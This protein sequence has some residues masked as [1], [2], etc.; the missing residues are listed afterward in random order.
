MKKLIATFFVAAIV[1]VNALAQAP[2][3]LTI[4]PEPPGLPSDLFYGSVK[5]KPVRLRPGTNTPITIADYDFFIQQQYIDFLRRFPEPA[6]LK[7]YVDI[8][9]GCA[10]TDVECIKY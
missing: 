1:A 2:P 8:L 6:G 4:V 7:F 9:N 5:V 3:T 10:P